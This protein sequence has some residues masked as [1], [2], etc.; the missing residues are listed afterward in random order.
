MMT[1]ATPRNPSLYFEINCQDCKNCI[2]AR[3]S[4][5]RVGCV[6]WLVEQE[7]L[8]EGLGHTFDPVQRRVLLLVVKYIYI[9]KIGE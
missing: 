3:Y 1:R 9:W 4:C 8:L 7:A 2:N 5:S 6:G